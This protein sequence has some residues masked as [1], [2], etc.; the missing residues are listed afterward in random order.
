MPLG[1]RAAA[2]STPGGLG[3][4][5]ATAARVAAILPTFA[6]ATSIQAAGVL[7]TAA[8]VAVALVVADRQRRALAMLAAP[9]LAGLTLATLASSFDALLEP[10][11]AAGAAAGALVVLG[12]AWLVH[13]RPVAFALLAVAALPF[14]VPVSIG[15]TAA[16]LL[17]PLYA[18]IAAGT[19]SYAWRAL[20]WRAPDDDAR[21]RLLRWLAWGFAAVLLLYGLQ[22]TYSTDVEQAIKNV[23]LF[24]VPFALLFLLLLEM[25]WSVR[26][27][28]H[29]L[30]VTVGLALVFAAI[31]CVEFAT[32]HLLITNAKVVEAND[33]LPYFRVNSL[34]FDPNIYGRYLALTMILLAAVL[35]WTRRRREAVLIAAALGL[36]WVGL[37]FSLSQS[38]FAALLLGLGVLAALRWKPWPVL[39]GAGLAA[40]VALGLVLFAPATLNLETGSVDEL[41]RATS[42]RAN[43]IGGGL[44][45]VRDRPVYGFGS[46][47][48]AER[49]RER[50]RV[51]SEKVAAASH[52]IPLTVTAEQGVIGLAAYLALVALSLALLFDGL[53]AGSTRWPGAGMVARAA[54]AAAYS[55]LVLHTLV[56]AAYLEDP[57]SWVLLAIA[58]GLRAR[59]VAAPAEPE[60]ELAVARL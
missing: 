14:R 22:A 16:N 35:L 50:E 59:P 26:L 19:L 9:A 11:V 18:V 24:Y 5:A 51:S 8:A 53:R 33:L 39:A 28:R 45:M 31:G 27:L 38:S 23:C 36:L 21:E 48:Y 2:P 44:R 20:R 6:V 1:A 60:P 47:S 12:F 43:L 56:Y 52:T 42:G 30:L 57:L 25:R 46:G 40:L 34:F 7:A 17:L 58:A 32:G 49:Y 13:R 3:R 29:S 41:D 55:A 37:V 4:L 10:L 54:L 15:D